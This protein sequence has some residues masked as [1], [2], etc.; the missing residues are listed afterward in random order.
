MAKKSSPSRAW[1][2][3]AIACVV[4]LGV[5]E[6]LDGDLSI[7][8][9]SGEEV[10]VMRV[11]ASLEGPVGNNREL[12]VSVTGLRVPANVAVIFSR[13]EQEIRV[14]GTPGK[15]KH[16]RLMAPQGLSNMG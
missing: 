4:G 6:G 3:S 12:A 1:F 10:G 14:P 7:K 8:R 13:R 2:W 9:R 5:L 15:G 11:P 16:T